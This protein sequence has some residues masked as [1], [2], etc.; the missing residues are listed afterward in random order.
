MQ[1]GARGDHGF[2]EPGFDEAVTGADRQ[3]RA[4][5]LLKMRSLLFCY[6]YPV[7]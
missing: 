1:V 7:M 4:A 3:R 6:S 2:R 5:S